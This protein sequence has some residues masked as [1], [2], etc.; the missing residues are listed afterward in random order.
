MSEIR[1]WLLS[2]FTRPCRSCTAPVG[3]YAD[4]C[5]TCVDRLPLERRWAFR[6][7]YD[8]RR[9]ERTRYVLAL[10]GAVAWLAANPKSNAETT[11]TRERQP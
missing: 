7:A 2:L 8:S 3:R 10:T 6:D 4:L 1:R 9:H 11:T 5:P